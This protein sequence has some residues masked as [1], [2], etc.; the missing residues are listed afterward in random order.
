MSCAFGRRGFLA[1][2]VAAF[3]GAS[4]SATV[5][6]DGSAKAGKVLDIHV[7]LFGVGDAGS[8]CRLSKASSKSGLFQYLAGKLRLGKRAKT[9]D[10]GYVLALAEQVEKS[11]L[12]KAVILAQDAV[13]DRR[14]KP[15]WNKS[16]SSTSPTITCCRLWPVIRGR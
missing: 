16:S 2:A 13:Y 11:G 14:G 9:T 6:A 8:G 3:W 10:E 7:H 12:D 5:K 4:P 15:D 1:G